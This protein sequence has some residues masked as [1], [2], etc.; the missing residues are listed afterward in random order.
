[1]RDVHRIRDQARPRRAR[2]ARRQAPLVRADRSCRRSAA[3]ACAR[4][5]E[6]I[7][8]RG[9]RARAWS[10]TPRSP[11]TS[12]RPRRSG[13]CAKCSAKRRS[14]EG[15]SIKHD[16]SVPVADRAGSSS[17]RRPR[18][19]QSIIPGGRPVPFGHVGDGNIHFNVSQPVGADKA[20]FLARWDEI[21][22]VVHEIVLKYGGSISAEH[23]V[24]MHQARHP[25]GDE[26]PGGARTDARL[27]AHARPE[28]HPQSG[29]GALARPQGATI[30]R[31]FMFG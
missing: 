10:R 28:R 1:M 15:G 29:Q 24:G 21:N 31:P 11:P 27:E 26:G 2:P 22:A 25:A 6:A 16:V 30:T 20:Q 14:H 19:S 3:T 13:A 18:R 23:G 17:R 8:R 12:S 7:A 4:A 9:A 5:M